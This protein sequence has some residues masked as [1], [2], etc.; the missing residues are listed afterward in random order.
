MKQCTYPDCDR[1]TE[2]ATDY[3]A[4]H[5][6]EIRKAKSVNPNKGY[7]SPTQ[8]TYLQRVRQWKLGKKCAL[9][10]RDS[11]KCFGPITC[12]HKR[13]RTGDLLMDERYWLP[14]CVGHHTYIE[15]HPE[16]SYRNGW[17]ELRLASEPHKI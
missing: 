15:M 12:H 13:G 17:S 5:G 3:C 4:T 14:V 16:E 10:H 8:K 2:G 6:R 9:R 7:S 1:L 11:E